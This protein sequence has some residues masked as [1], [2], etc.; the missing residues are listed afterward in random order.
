MPNNLK[1]GQICLITSNDCWVGYKGDIC[2][3]LV[4]YYNDN[5]VLIQIINGRDTG[6]K[7]WVDTT[8]IKP[9]SMKYY[10]EKV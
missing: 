3:I 7:G 6:A 8:Y 1:V 2:K 10:Y 9:I 5:T 4:V